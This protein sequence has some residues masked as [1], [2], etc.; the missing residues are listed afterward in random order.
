M[1]SWILPWLLARIKRPVW[2]D[3][4]DVAEV[5]LCAIGFGRREKDCIQDFVITRIGSVVHWLGGTLALVCLIEI[6]FMHCDR[7]GWTLGKQFF[8]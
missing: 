3:G 5:G 2:S 1:R 4:C 8:S 6:A 7:V